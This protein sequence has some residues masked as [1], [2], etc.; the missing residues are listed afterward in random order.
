MSSRAQHAGAAGTV[1]LLPAAPVEPVAELATPLQ[2]GPFQWDNGRRCV[3][4]QP[5][6]HSVGVATPIRCRARQPSSQPTMVCGTGAPGPGCVTR[7]F[8]PHADTAVISTRVRTQDETSRFLMVSPVRVIDVLVAGLSKRDGCG[9]VPVV[10]PLPVRYR[11]TEAKCDRQHDKYVTRWPARDS[12][13]TLSEV[14]NGC[15]SSMPSGSSSRRL[16]C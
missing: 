3:A 16:S 13:A 14:L 10:C 1:Y 2:T 5:S 8:L 6:S 9:T 12:L 7:F 11:V 15:Y 4:R